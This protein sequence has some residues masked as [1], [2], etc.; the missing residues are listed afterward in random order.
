MNDFKESLKEKVEQS[1]IRYVTTEELK[2]VDEKII[3][4]IIEVLSKMLEDS[5]DNN[6]KTQIMDR[7]LNLNELF[8]RG[9]EQEIKKLREL[10][11]SEKGK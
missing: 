10:D 4:K 6:E 11:S 3:T 2:E 5:N 1:S 8:N 9:F 7:I